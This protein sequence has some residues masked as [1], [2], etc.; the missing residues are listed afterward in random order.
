MLVDTLLTVQC[1]FSGASSVMVWWHVRH[2]TVG[3]DTIFRGAGSCGQ[4]IHSVEKCQL[5]H[6]SQPKPE[7]DNNH[8]IRRGL[9][10]TPPPPTLLTTFSVVI[11]LFQRTEVP[12]RLILITHCC[13]LMITADHWAG[14][15][16][17]SCQV[18]WT[19]HVTSCWDYN[20]TFVAMQ[21][22]W[23]DT[24]VLEMEGYFYEENRMES[25]HGNCSCKANYT[26]ECVILC[27]S[28]TDIMHMCSVCATCYH[29]I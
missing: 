2:R 13:Y 23:R 11:F 19:D 20:C 8:I 24:S 22:T 7:S 16:T 15:V 1:T 6:K 29:I 10:A 28:E 12:S 4:C 18:T 25:L 26:V 21:R 17:C 14:H 9:L 5:S 27:E 3:L